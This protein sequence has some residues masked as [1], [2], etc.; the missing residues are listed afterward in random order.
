MFPFYLLFVIIIISEY[1]T[2]LIFLFAKQSF[3]NPVHHYLS[4]LVIWLL[5]CLVFETHDFNN[6][7]HINIP[8]YPFISSCLAC[9]W[10]SLIV[11]MPWCLQLIFNLLFSQYTEKIKPIWW[12]TFLNVFIAM[13][14]LQEE[15][16]YQGDNILL[17]KNFE[18]MEFF[19]INSVCV[20]Y[21]CM[22]VRILEALNSEPKFSHS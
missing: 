18:V 22:R 2:L 13:R 10:F 6:Y 20:A 16:C 11:L 15:M 7:M 12:L 1:W 4:E 3:S 19:G 9:F 14:F 21:L 5:A 17:E 8:K